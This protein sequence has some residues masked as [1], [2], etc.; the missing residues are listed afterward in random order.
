MRTSCAGPPVAIQRYPPRSYNPLQEVV[1]DVVGD[2][3]SQDAA[4]YVGASCT[5]VVKA[6]VDAEEDATAAVLRDR[7]RESVE[8][9]FNT[10]S[11]LRGQLELDG[12]VHIE[13][14]QSGKLLRELGGVLRL[15]RVEAA[16]LQ[17]HDAPP[18]PVVQ[19]SSTSGPT[20]ASSFVTGSPVHR[21]GLRQIDQ[22]VFQED[23][24]GH[25]EGLRVEGRLVPAGLFDSAPITTWVNIR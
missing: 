23:P 2:L 14:C 15:P 3:L 9:A 13:V 6:P 21:D 24:C 19:A 20:A 4:S 12:V 11:V 1:P 17:Q 10:G 25:A 22:P 18:V 16:V 5:R 7:L 8:R